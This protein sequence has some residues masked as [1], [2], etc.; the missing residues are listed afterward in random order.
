MHWLAEAGSRV[1]THTDT[2]AVLQTE[3][4]ILRTFSTTGKDGH[5]M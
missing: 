2:P 4:G 1:N 5:S 3:K